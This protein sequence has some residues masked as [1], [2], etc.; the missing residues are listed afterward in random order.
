MEAGEKLHRV[1]KQYRVNQSNS[2]ELEINEYKCSEQTSLLHITQKHTVTDKSV[3]TVQ[4]LHKPPT[5]L[6][7][8]GRQ[9]EKQSLYLI[10]NLRQ[11]VCG[12]L[13]RLSGMLVEWGIFIVHFIVN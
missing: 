11:A 3:F 7:L 5:V 2:S 8:A 10:L 12:L 4:E 9:E 1:Q 6:C 13:F